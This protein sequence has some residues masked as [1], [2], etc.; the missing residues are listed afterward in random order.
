MQFNTVYAKL[1][2]IIPKVLEIAFRN[3][4]DLGA[5]Y[6]I[7][8]EYSYRKRVRGSLKYKKPNNS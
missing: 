6:N 3:V 2:T 4:E 8:K 1:V 7:I 5:Y